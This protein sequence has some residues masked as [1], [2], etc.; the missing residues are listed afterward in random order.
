MNKKRIVAG[1]LTSATAVSLIAAGGTAFASEVDTN[2]SKVGIGFS[3]HQPGGNGTLNLKW[4]PI[5]L[6]FGSSNTVNT[7]VEDFAEQDE[8][9][10]VRKFAVVEDERPHDSSDP[11]VEWKLTAKVS[12][13]V[14]TSNS[15]T[16]LD[17]AVLKFDTDKHG[18]EGALPPESGGIIPATAQHTAQ[19]DA[20]YS[21]TTG[22]LAATEVM[23]DG[24]AASG[25]TSF[26]GRTAMEMKNIKLTVPANVAQKGHQYTGDLTW[27]LDDT[28]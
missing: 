28:I 18:H 6:D 20:S 21:L 16:K 22:A 12:E 4:T 8:V 11:D 13:L 24:D 27:S 14:S 3:A 17:G 7:A 10:G 23:K 26:G 25:P 5:E 19:M 1:L 15:A 2:A 9:G